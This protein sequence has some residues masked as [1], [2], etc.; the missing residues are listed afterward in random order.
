MI[1]REFV[2]FFAGR[3]VEELMRPANILINKCRRRLL[4]A[5]LSGFV[6]VSSAAFAQTDQKTISLVAETPRSVGQSAYV[7]VLTD[8]LASAGFELAGDGRLVLIGRGEVR[9]VVA[10]NDG[11][12]GFAFLQNQIGEGDAAAALLSAPGAFGGLSEQRAVT[13]GVIGDAARDEVNGEGVF[14]LRL[15]PH[16]TSSLVSLTQLASIDDFIGKKTVTADPYSVAFVESL[17]AAPMQMEFAEVVTGLMVGAAD[18]AILPQSVV[19]DDV[20]ELFLDGTVVPE[21]KTQIGVTLVSS[22]WWQTLTAGE[23][24]RLLAALDAAEAAAAAAVQ[25]STDQAVDQALERGIQTVSWRSFEASDIRGAVSNSISQNSKVDAEP[26]LQLRDEIKELEQQLDQDSDPN[27]SEEKGSLEKPARVFFASNRR[28]DPGEQMLIDRFANTEDSSNTLRCGEL[29]PPGVGRIGSVQ[30]Q[31]RLLGGAAITEGDACIGLISSAVQDT[32]GQVLIH[33]H[34]YRNTFDDAVRAGLAFSR[35]AEIEG[36]VIVW[37]WPSAGAFKSYLFDEESIVISEPLFSSF[38]IDLATTD[39]V[40]QVDFVAHSMGSRLL[41]NLMRDEW[42][43]QPSAVAL[44]APDV[45]RHFLKQAVQTAQSAAVTL[46]ATEGD[47]AL[48]ASRKIHARTRAG[49]A[50][51]LFL[52][53]GMDTIDLTAFDRWWA[54]N[55]GHAFLERE[56]VADLARLFKGEWTAVSR[57]LQPFP[58]PGSD[59]EHFRIGPDGS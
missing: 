50:E 39:G 47:L 35:D 20:F 38:V 31:V 15:W 21:Y 27:D 45:S 17:G 14:A 3:V 28:F 8:E 9:G 30:E 7:S 48:L 25:E 46:L 12:L 1:L 51:P 52:I 4:L 58:S 24:R 41:A 49:Q 34:G 57:G 29:T 36:V 5:F 16:S 32:G 33:V 37:S 40:E 2:P 13:Q 10:K 19:G 55:H 6:S 53:S 44:A 23:Q 22:S 43:G 42:I 11:T 59:I 56:I 18:A 54:N 26:I